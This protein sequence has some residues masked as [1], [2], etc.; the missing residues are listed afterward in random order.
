MRVHY[1]RISIAGLFPIP[2]P[3][4][5]ASTTS[6]YFVC[7]RNRQDWGM[8]SSRL[9]GS[10]LVNVRRQYTHS[11]KHDY[12]LTLIGRT[13]PCDLITWLSERTTGPHRSRDYGWE[14]PMTSVDLGETTI[15]TW[16][17]EEGWIETKIKKFIKK[18]SFQ[19]FQNTIEEPGIWKW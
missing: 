4:S 9:G 18:S 11:E 3:S 19:M 7:E 10:P 2:W 13:R 17:Q 5:G 12:I 14:W 1:L 15:N 16:R 6:T 8:T